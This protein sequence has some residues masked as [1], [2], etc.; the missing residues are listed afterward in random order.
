VNSFAESAN[1]IEAGA[2]SSSSAIVNIANPG[3]ETPAI[4]SFLYNPSGGSWTFS[5][6]SG[7]GS[8]AAANNSGF[9]Q[10]NPNAPEGVQV[11]F[12]QGSSIISQALSGFVRGKTYVISFSGAQ[13]TRATQLGQTW[14]VRIDGMTIGS[15]AP[16]QSAANYA[17]YTVAFTASATTHTLAFVGTNMNGGDNTVFLDDVRITTVP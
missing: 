5:G 7:N 9:T 2:T 13:R 10:A 6:A 1:S 4:P 17:D 3:F 12:L 16:P 8:G 14:D 11:A 15:F